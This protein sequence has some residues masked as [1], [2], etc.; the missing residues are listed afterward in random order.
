MATI[1]IM[2]PMEVPMAPVMINYKMP[3]PLPNREIGR[4]VI[5]HS[6][7]DHE[8]RLTI[9][10]LL[11]IS[12]TDPMYQNETDMSSGK[13]RERIKELAANELAAKSDVHDELMGWLERAEKLSELRNQ[14]VHGVWSRS[15]TDGSI[16]V[17]DTRY[18]KLLKMPTLKELKVA[19]DAMLQLLTELNRSRL[20]GKLKQAL[21]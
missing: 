12:I 7:L 5:R 11:R 4:V 1:D 17:R 19:D 3:S 13:L 9:K 16:K 10:S 2:S 20:K 6:H 21:T 14:L 18:A 15:K 8:L